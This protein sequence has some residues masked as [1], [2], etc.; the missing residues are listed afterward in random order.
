MIVEAE[1]PWGSHALSCAREE[2]YCFLLQGNELAEGIF[3]G[4]N[5]MVGM[6][7]LKN[8]LFLPGLSVRKKS[9]IC[10]KQSVQGKSF[11]NK[12]GCLR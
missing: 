12:K 7:E 3:E 4:R 8:V 10:E 5:L 11:L 2:L 9:V 1:P 6:C